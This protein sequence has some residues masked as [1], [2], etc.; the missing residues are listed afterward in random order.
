MAIPLKIRKQVF[1]RDQHCAH[2]GLEDDTLIIHHRKNRGLGGSKLLDTPDNLLVVCSAWNIDME[3][4]AG[5]AAA[6]RGWGHKLSAYEDTSRPVFDKGAHGWFILGADGS[7]TRV[8]D[9]PF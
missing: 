2:C 3:A 1:A 7:K 8:E 4:N 6:A 5:V 9:D